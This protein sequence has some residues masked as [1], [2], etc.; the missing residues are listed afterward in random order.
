MLHQLFEWIGHEPDLLFLDVLQAD[1]LDDI[2]LEHAV[3]PL[4]RRLPDAKEVAQLLP[5]PDEVEVQN[6]MSATSKELTR[7]L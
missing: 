7:M 6:E 3:Y 1:E 2:G 5:L 4:P